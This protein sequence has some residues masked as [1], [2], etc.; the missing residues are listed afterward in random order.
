M[1]LLKP[2]ALLRHLVKRSTL[3]DRRAMHGAEVNVAGLAR[4][5]AVLLVAD[6]VNDEEEVHLKL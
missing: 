3:V 2:Y 5:M 6:L 1:I 4:V